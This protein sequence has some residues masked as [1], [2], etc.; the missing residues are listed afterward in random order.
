[1]V[2]QSG[3]FRTGTVGPRPLSA[4]STALSGVV[5]APLTY[6]VPFFLRVASHIEPKVMLLSLIQMRLGPLPLRRFCRTNLS[7]A[8]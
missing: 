8:H 7:V 5:A 3:G 6:F 4:I 1:M 2:D